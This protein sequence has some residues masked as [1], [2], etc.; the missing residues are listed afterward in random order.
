[1]SSDFIPEEIKHL[2]VK[3]LLVKVKTEKVLGSLETKEEVIG[4]FFANYK[5]RGGTE[6]TVNGK[7]VIEDTADIV[8]TW[9]PDIQSDCRIVRVDHNA[10]FEIVGEP[11]DYSYRHIALGFTVRRLKGKFNP[12]KSDG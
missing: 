6:T 7:L 5:S 3:F 2:N 8:T 1:M 4:S 10:K 9:R 12:A 11:E